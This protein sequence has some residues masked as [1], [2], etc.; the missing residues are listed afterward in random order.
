MAV[1]EMVVTSVANDLDGCM[2]SQF[3][4]SLTYM[5][6]EHGHQPVLQPYFSTVTPSFWNILIAVF[7]IFNK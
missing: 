6:Q 3:I 1:G 4:W 5:S 7:G 2:Q